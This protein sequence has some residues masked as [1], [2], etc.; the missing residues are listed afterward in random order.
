MRKLTKAHFNYLARRINGKFLKY[1]EKALKD[2]HGKELVIHFS[3][4]MLID[5]K[6]NK[7]NTPAVQ[8]HITSIMSSLYNEVKGKKYGHFNHSFNC[9][10][11]RLCAELKKQNP[12]FVESKFREA[13]TKGSIQ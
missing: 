8:E 5:S 7:H 13:C 12:K 3:W 6:F 10:M 2:L 4:V 11:K 1:E 9:F